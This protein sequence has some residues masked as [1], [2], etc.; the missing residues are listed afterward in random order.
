MIRS[1]VLEALRARGEPVSLRELATRIVA[2][3]SP[4]APIVARRVVAAALG[5]PARELPDPLPAEAL[6]PAAAEADATPLEQATFAVVDLETTGL[7]PS[8][9]VIL[10]IGAVR[11]RGLRA[12]D[13]F[14]T[15]VD[16]GRPVPPEITALTG[17]AAPMLRGA[18]RTP[19]ALAR[20]R[21]WLDAAPG[22]PFVA[23]NAAFD[24]GFVRRGFAACG[25]APLGAPVLCTRKLARR[26]VPELRRFGLAEL[27]GAFGIHNR[28]RHRALGDAEATAEALVQ[29]LARARASAGVASVGELLA[30]QER[31][32][33]PRAGASGTAGR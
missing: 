6:A 10:E 9:S 16:C 14:E 5:R 27:A 33:R 20:F 32:P 24:E 1:R 11:V 18:P 15:L 31:P 19:E 23:H 12:V 28:A 7:S 29:L 13:R 4:V 30:F 2:S 21:R 3:P 17:I 22:A 25:L 26:L 8:R